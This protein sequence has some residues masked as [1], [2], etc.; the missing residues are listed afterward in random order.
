MRRAALA[1]AL[2][3]ATPAA[4]ELRGGLR[5]GNHPDHG[6]VVVDWPRRVEYRLEEGA[7]RVVLRFPEGTTIDP[8]GLRPPRNATALEAAEGGLAITLAPGT[9][10]RHFRLDNRVVV[11]L[12]DAAPTPALAL[13]QPQPPAAVPQR[14]RRARTALPHGQA[15]AA[16][17]APAMPVAPVPSP[18]G[19]L[20]PPAPR[21]PAVTAAGGAVLIPAPPEVGA[22][23]LRRGVEWLLVL[24]APLPL[25]PA[26]LRADPRF[27][28]VLLA[29]TARATL[30]RLPAAAAPEPRLMRE[31][32]GWRLETASPGLLRSILPESEPG[33]PNRLLLRA[34]RPGEVVPV[35][36]PLTGATMLVGTSR[37]DGEATRFGRRAP[38][39][40][41]LP[42][43]LGVA[44]LPR[45]DTLVLRALADRFVAEAE[46]GSLALGPEPL[47]GLAEAEAMSRHFD[48]PAGD[49]GALWAR[50][51][52]AMIAV[53]AAPPLGRAAPRLRAAEAL[54]ALGLGQEAQAMAALAMRDDP[55]AAADRRAQ[56]LHAA[57][58]LVG[59]RI[60]EAGTLAG[61]DPPDTDE[62][63]LWRGL[64]AAARG[65]A[66]PG[67]AAK[68]PLLLT[69]PEPLRIRLLPLAAEA[70]AAGPDPSAARRLL[71]PQ[72]L[73]DPA[74]ALARARL[75]E[76][77][78]EVEHALVAYDALATGRDRRMRA[79]AMRRAAELRLATGRLD[80]AGAAAAL[81]ATLAAWRGDAAESEA[82]SR[83]AELR[84]AAGDPRGAFEL[85]GETAA[86]FP[87][88]AP[89]LRARQAAALLAALEG[90]APV[91]AAALHEAHAALL[92][93]GPETERALGRL[94]ER[95][96]ALDLPDRA[97]HL[98]RGAAARAGSSPARARIG[99]RMAELALGS[100]NL[101]A[102]RA[103]LAET[104]STDL[105][106]EL[107][108]HRALLEA[109]ILARAGQP[110]DAEA[111]FREAGAVGAPEW[112][113]LLAARQDWPAAARVLG[114]HLA[115]SLPRPPASLDT[116]QQRLVTRHAA[117]LAL[118]GEA[119]ALARLSAA[120]APRMA[121]SPL[122]DAFALLTAAPV[123]AAADLPRARQELDTAR[124]LPSRLESLRE[125]PSP[126]R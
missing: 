44:L 91:A 31:A 112:A 26:P 107:R 25:D 108:A 80:A 23:L 81:E 74:L 100:G 58:A 11:D 41:L 52:S 88:L 98:L 21:A 125:A 16:P 105:P 104:A 86:A 69:Y 65:E 116:A 99:A 3:V 122:G 57:A 111:R 66:A 59:G 50:E 90:E 42:T 95:L 106:A 12:L 119:S 97:L 79:A 114:A 82:R 94:A 48:L 70:L 18:A 20:P 72:D 17:P 93:A 110:A 37:A 113:E 62:A 2:L 126:A 15:D 77:E 63:V 36:D 6:R 7:G 109:R 78:G 51:R 34:T 30:L 120:E 45:A 60:G 83:L 10:L 24:D 56:A 33:A 71:V 55:R 43:R 89:A 22:A 49:A 27:G 1:L 13:A 29:S 121:G 35:L 103:A 123:G 101:P 102:A 39:F 28:D 85:L 46:D 32:A 124:A 117:L 64:L 8:R 76:A 4:A 40:E 84:L 73:A 54:L 53:A 75:M 67:L 5:V 92:P 118:A 14:S 9:R 19:P 115:E 47:P 96:A 61:P 87:D 38:V 68:L